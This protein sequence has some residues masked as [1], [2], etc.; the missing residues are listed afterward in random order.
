M[1]DSILNSDELDALRAAVEQDV[2]P[3]EELAGPGKSESVIL[4][5]AELPRFR[6][7]EGRVG[8][9]QREERLS[10]VF[11]K[12][13]RALATR[14]A[15]ILEAAVDVSVTWLEETKFAAFRETFKAG[16]VEMQ[17]SDAFPMMPER[18]LADTRAA[19]PEDAIITTDVGWN[20]NGVG[21]QFDI[22]TPGSIL[23]PGGFEG[24][25]YEMAE[26]RFTI[27]DDMAAITD[28]AARYHL[29]FTGPPLG[30]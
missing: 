1:M 26:G 14:L 2:L 24:F 5:G 27:P 23:T 13:A 25:F 7:G 4:D 17:T 30:H 12:A 19:L 16:N 18:I 22:L 28:I 29:T 3:Q 9:V 6:F 8:A 10:V 21:Q 20:K 15:D 11:D